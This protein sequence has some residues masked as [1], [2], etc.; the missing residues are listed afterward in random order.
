MPDGKFSNK[1][2]N[3]LT[4][5][6][7]MFVNF[8]VEISVIHDLFAACLLACISKQLKIKLSN[9]NIEGEKDG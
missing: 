3:P 9:T 8:R 2:K 6:C 7:L 5:R 1:T 4:V